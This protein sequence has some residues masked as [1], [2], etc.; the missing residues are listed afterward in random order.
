MDRKLLDSIK[1]FISYF[2]V[3]GISALVEWGTF[4]L[5]NM[6][7]IHYLLATVLSFCFSTTT[8]W[9]LG[10]KMT[11]KDSAYESKRMKELLLV[12]FASAIGLVFNLGLMYLFVNILGMNT[13]LLKLI[14]KVMATGIV[15]VWNFLSRKYAIYKK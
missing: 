15:F 4:S 6:M 8:N 14:A 11:F 5:F 2:F 7:R 13:D 3:G 9:F 12:F 10:R 1:Q